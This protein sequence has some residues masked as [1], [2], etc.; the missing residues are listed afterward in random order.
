MKMAM[1]AIEKEVIRH[2]RH[3]V[4]LLTQ[5][6]DEVVFAV[7]KE[8]IAHVVRGITH[9]MSHALSILVP[10]IVTAKVGPSLGQLEEW[11]VDHEL[12]VKT[13]M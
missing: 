4:Y 10:L 1:L 11:S 5:I 6:H 7:R 9:A 13:V 3:E 8:H 12:G 2:Y